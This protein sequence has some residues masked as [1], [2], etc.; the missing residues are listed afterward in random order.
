MQ[1]NAGRS[2]RLKLMTRKSKLDLGGRIVGVFLVVVGLA[3]FA[4][5]AFVLMSGDL[6]LS[7]V[8]LRVAFFFV[9]VG[10]LLIWV[11]SRFLKVEPEDQGRMHEP[12]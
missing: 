12:E 10:A 5:L 3:F 8:G 4:L 7:K 6:V 1:P 2:A 9:G 11:G